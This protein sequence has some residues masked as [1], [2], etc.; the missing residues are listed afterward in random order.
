M[1]ENNKMSTFELIQKKKLAIKMLEDQEFRLI[2]R[3]LSIN[4]R[5]NEET[6]TEARIAEKIRKEKKKLS[7][8]IRA[9]QL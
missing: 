2:V 3:K 7:E 1:P 9:S 5:I 8:L 6:A 4:R